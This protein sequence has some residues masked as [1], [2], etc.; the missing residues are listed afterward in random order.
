MEERSSFALLRQTWEGSPEVLLD[1]ETGLLAQP[2]E[3]DGF[4]RQIGR[5]VNDSELRLRLAR[6][7]A[8]RASQEFSVQKAIGRIER[9]YDELLF[10]K[11]APPSQ[12]RPIACALISISEPVRSP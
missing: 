4:V 11:R 6:A 9:L 1:G 2:G 3:L 5:A 8:A 7:A 10:A 12:R